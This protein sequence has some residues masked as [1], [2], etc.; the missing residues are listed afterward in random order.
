M[1]RSG[2]DN[3]ALS[4]LLS[5]NCYILNLGGR[6]YTLFIGMTLY[7]LTQLTFK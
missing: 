6:H 5:I 7:I 1:K 4:D 3:A 2:L